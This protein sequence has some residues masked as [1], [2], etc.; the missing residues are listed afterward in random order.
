MIEMKKLAILVLISFVFLMNGYGQ[1]LSDL[2]MVSPFHDGLASV[3]KD[4]KWGFIDESGDLVV[5]FRDDILPSPASSGLAASSELMEYPVFYEDRCLIH[6][7]VDGIEYFGFIDRS[8]KVAVE[9]KYVNATNFKNGFAM[10]TQYTRQVIGKNELLGKDVVVYHIEELVI[11]KSGKVA[12][13]L[14]NPRN[15]VPKKIKGDPPEMEAS[16]LGDRMVAVKGEDGKW[17]IYK[18]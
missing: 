9:P 7:V 1:V 2:D 15:Y 13:S 10:V 12:I 14:M 3:K 18:F 4:G 5:D 8:G 6:N 11:D 17:S 16:F